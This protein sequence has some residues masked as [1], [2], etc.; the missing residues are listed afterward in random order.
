M[1][2]SVQR[3]RIHNYLKKYAYYPCMTENEK[4]YEEKENF[5]KYVF[6]TTVSMPA[7]EQDKISVVLLFQHFHL[8]SIMKKL[9]FF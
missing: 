4:I 6:M 3:A 8:I 9:I 5:R 1:Q 7:F 2:N